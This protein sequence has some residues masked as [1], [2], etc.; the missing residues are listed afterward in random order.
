MMRLR[1]TVLMMM[2]MMMTT[3]TTPGLPLSPGACEH[4]VRPDG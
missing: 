4:E 3:T 2:M 1:M